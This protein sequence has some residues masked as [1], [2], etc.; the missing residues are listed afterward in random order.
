MNAD[1]KRHGPGGVPD[2]SETPGNEESK[3]SERRRSIAE[4]AYY[5]AERRGFAEGRE[6]DDWLEAERNMNSRASGKETAAHPADAGALGQLEAGEAGL[7][8]EQSP[9]AASDP[10]RIEPDQVKKWAR[11]LNVSAPRLR[12]AIKRVGP[13]VNDVKRFLESDAPPPP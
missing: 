5:N 4:A 6:L 9:A 10:D 12:E 8:P 1:H 13:V 7:P 2:D 3:E 11:Q